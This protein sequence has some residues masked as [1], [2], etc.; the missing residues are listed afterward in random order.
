MRS[1]QRL[2]HQ[3]TPTPRR[4]RDLE[5]HDQWAISKKKNLIWR[6]RAKRLAL[7]FAVVGLPLLSFLVWSSSRMLVE[8]WVEA[9]LV[10]VSAP[11]RVRVAELFV[12]PGESCRRGDP[13]LRL[14]PLDSSAL[15]VLE[16]EVQQKRLRLELAKHGGNVGLGEL[17]LR[18]E[19]YDDA[20]LAAKDADAEV[21]TREAQLGASEERYR[22]ARLSREEA[23][24]R[25]AERLGKLEGAVELARLAVAGKL[26]AL[27][28]AEFDAQSQTDLEQDGIASKRGRLSAQ[29][30]REV[31]QAELDAA[32]AALQVAEQTL[33]LGRRAASLEAQALDG[34]L[35]AETAAVGAV[36]AMREEALRRSELRGSLVA[37]RREWLPDELADGAQL[38]RLELA[39]LEAE[40]SG[41][42]A[43]LRA[44][45]IRRG[46]TV[47][48]A[49]CDGRVDRIDARVGT[50]VSA[51]ES[52]LQ[53][54]DP[55]SVRI[56]G[57][58]RG[59][60]A[61]EATAGVRCNVVFAGTSTSLEAW[62]ASVGSSLQRMPGA[63]LAELDGGAIYGVPLEIRPAPESSAEARALLRPNMRARIVVERPG[64]FSRRRF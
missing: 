23:R 13:L 45:E 60:Q 58:A 47:V 48:R 3:R 39:L 64:L 37:D 24:A 20:L 33:A 11:E 9:D 41:A 22:A 49:E 50:V 29:T 59:S 36:R 42:E 57:F 35:A 7:L 53:Y 26:A 21:L 15:E 1:V 43:R 8:G 40:V 16:Q 51:G 56:V 2:R 5:R 34:E 18:R 4:K 25:A 27:R 62:V 10:V 44:E 6:A 14:E 38:R 19:R 31:V 54:Y 46:R 28:L 32:Q 63:V 12:Q 55:A 17:S 61:F 52:L 30:D